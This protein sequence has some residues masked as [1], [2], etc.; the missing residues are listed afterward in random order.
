MTYNPKRKSGVL[1]HISSLPSDFGIGD[2]GPSAD[3]FAQF[4]YAA[5]FSAW[6]V[7]PLTPVNPAMGNSPY[8]AISAFAGNRLL[9]SPEELVADGL[10]SAADIEP[11]RA[12][13]SAKTDYARAAEIKDAL[14][15][16]AWRNFSEGDSRFEELAAGFAAFRESNAH[17]LRDFALFCA[18]KKKFGGTGRTEWP[19]EYRFRDEEAA[20]R[21]A[22]EPETAENTAYASFVQFIFARQWRRVRSFC[23][24]LDIELIGDLPIYVSDDSSDVWAAERLFDLDGEGRPRSVAGVPPD[25]FSETGQKWGNPLYKWDVMEAESFGWWKSRIAAALKMFDKVRVDHFR[26]FCGYWAVPA[27][28]KTAQNGEWRDAPGRKLFAELEDFLKSEGRESL[29]LIAEDLGVITDDVR[30]L[31]DEFSLPGMKVLLFAFGGGRPGNPY[32]PYNH[33]ARSVVYTGTH[34]NNTVLGWWNSA[35]EEERRL[36]ADYAGLEPEAGSTPR[37]MIRLAL[38]SR[39]DLA[40][41]PA[42]DLLGLGADCRMNEPGKASG[43]WEWRL[44][45]CG[46]DALLKSAPELLRMNVVYGRA[47]AA[48]TDGQ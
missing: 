2:M 40:V 35:S 3:R 14:L 34:D 37:A 21:Y 47:S 8:S 7:L 16:K 43:C 42:Q 4:L 15:K 5:G 44:E 24:M 30:E 19:A 28:E 22:A 27:S 6:Q 13:P 36:F 46:L 29:P 10:L 38:S 23:S 20:A 45:P 18:L 31:M 12:A 11:Y 32:L 39:S 41:V 33:E 26:G 1:L 25:Y 17:W 48:K 9:I